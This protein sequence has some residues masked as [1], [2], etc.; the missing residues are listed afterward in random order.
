MAKSYDPA[1]VEKHIFDS[2][3]QGG[4]FSAN[5]DAEGDPF[6]MVIPPPNVTGAL[7][8]GHALNNTLQDILVRRARMSWAI[9][10]SACSCASID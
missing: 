5:P 9:S 4:W 1:A 7:H 6:C 10:I 8:L 2:W 3:Q